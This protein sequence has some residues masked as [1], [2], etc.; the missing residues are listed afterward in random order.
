M[1]ASVCRLTIFRFHFV[2]PVI[3]ATTSTML[4]NSTWNY[5]LLNTWCK[6]E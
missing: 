4:E 6:T 2:A 5:T 3:V 1:H